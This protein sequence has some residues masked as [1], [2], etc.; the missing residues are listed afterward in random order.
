VDARELFPSHISLGSG[1][2]FVCS[3]VIRQ[4]SVS[5]S[6]AHA[7]ELTLVCVSAP[8]DENRPAVNYSQ[9]ISSLNSPMHNLRTSTD[10]LLD[11]VDMSAA[12]V[13]STAAIMMRS[14]FN[15]LR[16]LN[17]V[18]TLQHLAD[19]TT[20]F[21]AALLDLSRFLYELTETVELI[22]SK[23]GMHIN[24]LSEGSDFRCYADEK[25]IEQLMLNLTSNRLLH[26]KIGGTISIALSGDDERVSISVSDDGE[27][28]DEP[29]LSELF[30][31]SLSDPAERDFDPTSGLGLYIARGIA[32]RHGGTILIE[33]YPDRGT[34]VRVMIPSGESPR[35]RFATTSEKYFNRGMDTVLRELSGFLDYKFYD[36]QYLD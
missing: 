31:Y 20:P 3:A 8:R 22:I 1:R 26:M 18:A 25:L 15:V 12:R 16:T 13:R 7:D 24:F 35:N 19:G 5:V 34:F 29:T 33:S 21:E 30:R 27:G 17:N 28:I 10:W 32:E 2:D 6:V 9:V 14:Y 4:R 11:R 23:M 36:R